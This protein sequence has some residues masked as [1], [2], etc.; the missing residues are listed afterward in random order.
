M[1]PPSFAL[2]VPRSWRVG[3]QPVNTTRRIMPIDWLY[4]TDYISIIKEGLILSASKRRRAELGRTS[5]R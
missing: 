3:R 1:G 5:R 4:Y 2:A